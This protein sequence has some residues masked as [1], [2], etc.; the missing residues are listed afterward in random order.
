MEDNNHQEQTLL[1]LFDEVHDTIHMLRHMAGHYLEK[2]EE[3][4]MMEK[5]NHERIIK[6]HRWRGLISFKSNPF[7]K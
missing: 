3:L 5:V 4:E 7:H 1:E 2:A 6:Y